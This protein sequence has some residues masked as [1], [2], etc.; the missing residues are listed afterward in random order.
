ML[1]SVEISETIDTPENRYVKYFLEECA[2]V[3]QWLANHL[4]AMGKIAA[5]RSGKLGA[6]SSGTARTRCLAWCPHHAAVS[7]QLSDPA[8]TPGVQGCTA[9]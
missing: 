6:A 7:L 2:L 4:G 3:A 5:A 1:E 8:E 9:V